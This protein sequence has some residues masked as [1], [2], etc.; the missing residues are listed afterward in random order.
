VIDPNLSPVDD[1]IPYTQLLE[2]DVIHFYIY[3]DE[4]N[5][6]HTNSFPR[7]IELKQK[8]ALISK[9]EHILYP[10]R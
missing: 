5:Y 8:Q 6:L 2:V 3:V 7:D 9:K 4:L 1:D 10:N